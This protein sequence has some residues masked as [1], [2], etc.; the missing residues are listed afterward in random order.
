[1]DNE[2]KYLGIA[3]NGSRMYECPFCHDKIEVNNNV[4]YGRCPAC[5][6]TIIDYK[7]APHQLEFH[8]SNAKYRLNIGGLVI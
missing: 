1:M 2:L 5:K 3:S 4:F 8:R 7:P 6:A